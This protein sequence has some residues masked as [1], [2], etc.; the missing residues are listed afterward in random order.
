MSNKSKTKKMR[1][2]KTGPGKKRG[3]LFGIIAAVIVT[4]L[5][6]GGIIYREQISKIVQDNNQTTIYLWYTDEVLTDYL[7]SVALSYYD[8]KGI[9]VVPELHS[10]FEY[11]EAIGAAS[12]S[13]NNVPDL[14]IAGT[15]SIEIAAMSGI[16]IPV[17]DSRNVLSTLYYPQVAL[18]AVTYKGDS[19]GYPFYYETSF[20]LYNKSYLR[21]LAAIELKQELAKQLSGDTSEEEGDDSGMADLGSGEDPLSLPEGATQDVWDQ[22]IDE[23]VE[24][25]IPKSIQDIRTI[26]SKFAA[27]ENVESFLYW[28]VSDIFYTYF[29]TGAYMD[30]GGQYGDDTDILNICN[31]DTIWCM[32]IYQSLNQYFSIDSTESKYSDVIENFIAG[33][34]IYTIATSDAISKLEKA[35]AEGNFVYDYDIAKLPAVDANHLAKG[36]SYTNAVMINGFSEHRNEANDFAAYLAYNSAGNLYDRTGKMPASNTGTDFGNKLDAV[37]DVYAD[38]VPLPKIIE[39][40]NFW[41]KLEQAYTL[42][43]D[44]EDAETVLKELDNSMKIQLGR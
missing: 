42:V 20:L 16:A 44:G 35:K 15:D 1:T 8:D 5:L 29:I 11:L 39:L 38:S 26:A 34:Y 33:K 41:L 4:A 12:V 10:S 30:V 23:R 31:E 9:K 14:Y 25:F 37:K 24:Y 18:D 27:P 43:W 36:L 6:I 28:D 21:Q 19:F 17:N 7:N 3:P 13:D 22:A 2:S 32:A 40:S